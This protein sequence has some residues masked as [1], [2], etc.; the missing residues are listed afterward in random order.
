MHLATGDYVVNLFEGSSY[1]PVLLLLAMRRQ[2]EVP[3][4]VVR[5]ELA[6]PYLWYNFQ[7]GEVA[8]LPHVE[9]RDV[10]IASREVQWWRILVSYELKI[11]M[12]LSAHMITTCRDTALDSQH[13]LSFVE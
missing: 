7:S 1:D 13:E 10:S 8:W 4:D 5:A 11:T 3:W 6:D 9:D 2:C 12:L